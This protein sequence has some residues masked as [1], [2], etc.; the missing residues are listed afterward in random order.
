MF[1][2]FHSDKVFDTSPLCL[3]LNLLLHSFHYIQR[4]NK[5]TEDSFKL[6]Q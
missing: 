2:D 5:I 3:Q 6:Y 1:L 4:C